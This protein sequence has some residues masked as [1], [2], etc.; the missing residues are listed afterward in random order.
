MENSSSFIKWII[1][2]F[3]PIGWIWLIYKLIVMIGASIG[4]STI[5]I[6]EKAQNN[7]IFEEINGKLLTELSV[8]ELKIIYKKLISS[9]IYTQEYFWE[10]RKIESVFEYKYNISARKDIGGEGARKWFDNFKTQRQK[11]PE[12]YKEWY[13]LTKAG[14]TIFDFF[15]P[16]EQ[17]VL[18]PLIEESRKRKLEKYK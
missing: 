17:S 2:L 1:I 6:N 12:R 4:I 14:K 13:E 18:K 8:N 9:N 5:N 3:T 11:Y 16:E 15:S 10:I 7:K